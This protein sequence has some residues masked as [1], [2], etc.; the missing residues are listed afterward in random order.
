MKKKSVDYATIQW[1][2]G[3]AFFMIHPETI[4]IMFIEFFSALKEIFETL[5]YERVF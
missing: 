3:V 2:F 1:Q 4:L 5:P